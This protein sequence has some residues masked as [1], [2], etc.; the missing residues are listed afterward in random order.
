MIGLAQINEK[1]DRRCSLILKSGVEIVVSDALNAEDGIRHGFSTRIGGVSPSPFDTL[2]FSLSRADDPKNVID[3]LKLLSLAHGLDFNKLVF[4]NHEHGMNVIRVDKTH[5]GMGITREKLP[6]S[7]GLVTND[8]DITLL[9]CHADCGAIFLYDREHGAIGLAHS[10]WRGTLSRIGKALV[11][12]MQVEFQSKPES[13]IA[14]LG[15]C[16][17]KNCFEVDAELGE[18]FCKEFACPEIAHS[19]RSG[20]AYVDIEAALAI[21]LTDAGMLPQN[22]SSMNLC[23]FENRD[24]FFSYRRD[25]MGTGAMVSFLTL[26]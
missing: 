11:E 6:F 7:D 4:V 23:T 5:C 24:L 12:K 10:G 3:N 15:P 1:I 26:K 18:K 8:P 13:L 25:G 19:G 17:C 9:T 21:Q 20:K 14:A 16:I 22:I 2:N